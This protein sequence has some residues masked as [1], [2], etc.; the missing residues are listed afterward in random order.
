MN[1]ISQRGEAMEMKTYLSPLLLI[2]TF[3]TGCAGIHVDPG[4]SQIT[5][6]KREF[7]YEYSIPNK[8]KK[9]IIK[10]ARNFIASSYVN[11]KEISRVEDMEDGVII[12]KALMEWKLETGSPLIPFM[13][14]Y[15]NYEINF[16]AK[17][18]KARLRLYL[19]KGAA[20]PSCQWPL[21]PKNSYPQIAQEFERISKGMDEALQGHSPINKLKDF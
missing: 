20:S 15:S 18:E 16:V 4:M 17:D 1:L 9:E 3:I 7:I 6:E 21:P 5:D 10:N 19:I 12:A 14:C 2:S 13:P 8:N 11:S